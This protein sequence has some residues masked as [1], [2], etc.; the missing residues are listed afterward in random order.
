MR[1]GTTPTH[2]FTIPFDASAAAEVRVTYSVGG[3][4]I[5]RKETEDC[6]MDGTTVRV[7]LTQEETLRFPAGHWFS[8]QL[9]ALTTDG[10]SM[11]SKIMREPVDPCL[12]SEVL[13]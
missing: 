5:L 4:V 6:Q 8:A 9:R 10:E 13:L 12:D 7:K 1:Q 2:T 3:R 11:V